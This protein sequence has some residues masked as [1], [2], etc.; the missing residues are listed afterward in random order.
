MTFYSFPDNAPPHS[1]NRHVPYHPRLRWALAWTLSFATLYS[2]WA[3]AISLIQHRTYF[4]QYHLS[5][6]SIIAVYYVASLVCGL[7]LGF[8]YPLVGHRL[9]AVLL[10]SVLGFIAYAV[11]SVAM[12]GFHWLPILLALIPAVI[13]GGGLGLV[14]YDDNHKNGLAPQRSAVPDQKPLLVVGI[15]GFGAFFAA[16]NYGL[17]ERGLYWVA[18]LCLGATLGAWIFFHRNQGATTRPSTHAT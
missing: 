14:I 17:S 1:K 11:V 13:I 16:V 10:G 7:A 9:G 2:L 12:F 15:L 6:W 18:A 5:I 8:L 4:P 3:V